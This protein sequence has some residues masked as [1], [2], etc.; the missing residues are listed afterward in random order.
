MKDPKSFTISSFNV[1][2]LTVSRIHI[3]YSSCYSYFYFLEHI[4]Y[5]FWFILMRQASLVYLLFVCISCFSVPSFTPAVCFSLYLAWV[6][7]SF[8]FLTAFLPFSKHSW[9]FQLFLLSC[10]TMSY[11]IN[12]SIV[13]A[14]PRPT[15][16]KKTGIFWREQV[17]SPLWLTASSYVTKDRK[18]FIPSKFLKEKNFPQCFF[19]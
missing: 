2:L 8:F 13:P 6:F 5:V 19:F 12:S 9:I 15:L 10:A 11:I 3:L 16:L 7:L 18:P 17:H 14:V 4:F 1:K